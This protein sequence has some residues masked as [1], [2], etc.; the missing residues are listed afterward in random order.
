MQ[1]SRQNSKRDENAWRSIE[2]LRAVIDGETYET[3]GARFS[4]SRTAVERRIKAIAVQ[5]TQVVGVDGIKEE[6]A[7]FVRRLR[8]CR[9]AILV[10]LADFQPL[11]LPTTRPTRVFSAEEVA[12]GAVRIK[13]RASRTWHDLALYYILFSTGLR[14]LEI[15]RLEVRDYLEPDGS[16]RRESELRA[17]VAIN[18]KPRPLYFRSSRLDDALT[19]YLRERC[20]YGHGVGEGDA[21]HGLDPDSRLFLSPSGDAYKIL[22]NNDAPGQDRHVCRALL[23]IYRKLFRYAELKGFC[24]QSARLTLMSRMYERG[25][26]EEQVGVILGIAER[27]AVRELL[28]RPKPSFAELLDELI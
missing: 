27:S 26:D 8:L 6:G 21:Y 15:A 10:A 11:A 20:R 7:A 22:P 19:A 9:D 18:G 13:G 28:P 17:E 5:L 1:V 25:A 23:E 24:A 16:V 4:V 2:M 12:Q 14:P 3:V